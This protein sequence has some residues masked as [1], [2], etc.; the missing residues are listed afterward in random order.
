MGV[1]AHPVGGGALPVISDSYRR[2][3]AI[4]HRD[5]AYGTAARAHAPLVQA[6][7]DQCGAT[8]L[9]DYG[10]GKQVLRDLVTVD[11][12]R[13]YDPAIPEIAD[14]PDPADVVY[15]GDVMEHVEPEHTNAVLADVVRLARTA[16]VFVIS[17]KPASRLLDD[18]STAHRNVQPRIY[19]YR[20]LKGLGRLTRLPADERGNVIAVVR[21]RT[22]DD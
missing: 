3:N 12:Y 1:Q 4:A 7:I 14:A 11:E 6:V 13:A 19:W 2:L 9:L 22:A 20:R 16:A 10:A 8:S 18:G 5:P 17:T 15:C 21:P